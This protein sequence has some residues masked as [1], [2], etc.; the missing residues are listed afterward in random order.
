MDEYCATH[1][2]KRNLTRRELEFIIVDDKNKIIY[3]T[4]PKV[5]TTTWKRI[6][7][8]LRGLEKNVKIHR[9]GLWSRL[10]QYSAKERSQRLKSYFKF[11]F[12][13]EPLARLLSA[14]KDKFIGWDK[15]VS[16]SARAA[17][18]NAYRP[19]DFNQNENRVNFSEF[20]Q[21]FSRKYVR[22]NQHWRQ[23]ENLCHPCVIKYDFI[24]HLE[25]LGED[26]SLVLKM[27]G[28][29]NRV[30]FPPVHKSTGSSDVVDYYSKVPARYINQLGE[31]Y[32]ND[33]EMFGYDYLGSVQQ[34]LN[35]SS[36]WKDDSEPEGDPAHSPESNPEG[37]PASGGQEDDYSSSDREEETIN[38]ET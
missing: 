32:R 22:R 37:D 20:V 36:L 24:G 35:N 27:A 31:R 4:I 1:S 10:Y 33:F 2:Y 9:W 17:I 26:A 15:A 21:Y 3:C 12:V 38:F 8:D 14:F 34:L 23:Y 29:D 13:R 6:F 5:G 28:I 19:Q 25:T 7:A 18:V 16:N 11:L 30:T